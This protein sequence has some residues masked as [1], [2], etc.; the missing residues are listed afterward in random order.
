MYVSRYN[1]YVSIVVVTV[2]VPLQ[3]KRCLGDVWYSTVCDVTV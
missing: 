1:M 3:K 2:R